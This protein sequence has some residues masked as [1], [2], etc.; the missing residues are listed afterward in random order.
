MVRGEVLRVVLGD[1]VM[2][3]SYITRLGVVKVGRNGTGTATSLV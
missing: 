3:D 1:K 2:L